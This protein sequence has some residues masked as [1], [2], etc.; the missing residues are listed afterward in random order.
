MCVHVD[1]VGLCM[2]GRSLLDAERLGD[3]LRL[4]DSFSVTT[5]NVRS[6]LLNCA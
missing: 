3:E 1:V 4:A 5:C 2:V 6:T